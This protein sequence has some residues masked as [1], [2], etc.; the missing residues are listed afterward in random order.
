[1]RRPDN[2]R[3]DRCSCARRLDRAVPRA[4]RHPARLQ[5][6]PRRFRN[7][8][9]G[10]EPA[11]LRAG[12]LQRLL[13]L[14]DR[15]GADERRDHRGD[16]RGHRLSRR[17]LHFEADQG[18]EGGA[19]DR[20]PHSPLYR[21]SRAHIRL[22][23]DIG[24]GRR[25]EQL[26]DLDRRDRPSDR[27]LALQPDGDHDRLRVQL[28]SVHGSRTLA[29]LRNAR[30]SPV[31]GSGRPRRRSDDYLAPPR[32]AVDRA[33]AD[34]GRLDGFHFGRRRLSHAPTHRRRLRCDGDQRDC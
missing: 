34:R 11:Q 20:A 12:A 23:T 19:S 7:H 32:S 15:Q 24:P 4:A 13:S 31:R 6:L 28:S 16:H 18:G 30:R 29:E 26:F 10:P 2:S 3:G 17:V 21:R 9:A 27:D 22:A 14:F 25:V 8:C 5:L 1:M 33:R